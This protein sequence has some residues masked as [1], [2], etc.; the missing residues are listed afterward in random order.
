MVVVVQGL[1]SLAGGMLGEGKD[2]RSR[3]QS[4]WWV[5]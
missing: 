2:E 1:L 4:V 3:E 5:C